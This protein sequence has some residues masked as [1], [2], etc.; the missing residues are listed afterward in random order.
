MNG[1][2]AG[3]QREKDKFMSVRKNVVELAYQNDGFVNS[4]KLADAVVEHEEPH[5]A[6][7]VRKGT[8]FSLLSAFVREPV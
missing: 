5:Q 7:T 8:R 1:P 2:G 6:H 4:A 3:K